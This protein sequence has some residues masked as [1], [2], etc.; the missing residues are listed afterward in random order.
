MNGKSKTATIV[1][2]AIISALIVVLQLFIPPI[3]LGPFSVSLVL[4]PIVIGVAFCGRRYGWW[5]GLVFGA[6]VLFGMFKSPTPGDS[7]FLST[8][9][10]G[11]ILTVLSKGV[12]CGVCA[13][14]TFDLFKKASKY[15][16]VILSAIICPVVNT[17]VFLI[18]CRLFFMEPVS[19]WAMGAGFGGN[20][21]LYMFAGLVGLNFV[22]EMLTNIIL[23][24]VI[25]RL[26]NIGKK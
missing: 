11:T 19:E 1:M 3:P 25:L 9:L 16:A 5:F 10:I 26:I 22:F 12:L 2:C 14:V 20:V 23:S 7:I 8:S 24:P 6:C 13:G 4:V 17:G 18:G 21:V 15:L